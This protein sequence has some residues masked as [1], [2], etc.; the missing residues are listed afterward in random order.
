MPGRVNPTHS[1]IEKRL[2]R[3]EGLFSMI[4]YWEDSKF[5]P[6]GVNPTHSAIEK[7]LSGDSFIFN[8]RYIKTF[9]VIFLQKIYNI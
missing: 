5:M 2:S 3:S 7:S 6:G 9:L 8:N 1:A 4:A